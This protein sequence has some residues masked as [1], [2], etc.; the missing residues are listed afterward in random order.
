MDDAELSQSNVVSTRNGATIVING[1][2][3][4]AAIFS[5]AG[6]TDVEKADFATVTDKFDNISTTSAN[7]ISD[8]PVHLVPIDSGKGCVTR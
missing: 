8:T 5:L 3:G 7:F 6:L 4:A 1:T 2:N